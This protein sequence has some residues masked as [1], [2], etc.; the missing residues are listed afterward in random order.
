M[1]AQGGHAEQFRLQQ[2]EGLVAY[3][4]QGDAAVLHHLGARGDLLGDGRQRRAR[5]WSP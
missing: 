5:E 1:G 3:G 4:L 2:L